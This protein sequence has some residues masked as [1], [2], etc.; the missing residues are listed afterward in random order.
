MLERK[1]VRLLSL[2]ISAAIGLL[3]LYSTALA[4][5]QYVLHPRFGTIT[6]AAAIYG[7]RDLRVAFLDVLFIQAAVFALLASRGRRAF[8]KAAYVALVVSA[9]NLALPI[10]I[11]YGV[12]LSASSPSPGLWMR[13]A[14][15]AYQ[16]MIFQRQLV[17][18]PNDMAIWLAST[19]LA[20]AYTRLGR[21]LGLALLDSS[22][23]AFAVLGLFS[24]GSHIIDPSWSTTYVT[25]LQVGTSFQWFTND[26]LLAVSLT[27]LAAFFS[28][29][30][31]L[32]KKSLPRDLK[33]SQSRERK[34]KLF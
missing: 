21:G 33:Q 1:S 19:T 34:P 30:V 2:L 27:G 32:E 29:R 10:L 25:L 23:F 6:Y 18:L 12:N 28:A 9:A 22:C 15:D 4:P 17:D 11:D 31:V 5:L 26:D 8:R 14:S 13:A 7:W 3:L 16:A 24:V 20:F